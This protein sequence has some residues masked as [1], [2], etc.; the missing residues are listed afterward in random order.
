MTVLIVE[1][2]DI[3]ARVV[4]MLLKKNGF[5]AVISR[6][7]KEALEYFENA[8]QLTAAIV[9]IMMPEM[10]GFELVQRMREME[11]YTDLP[12]VMC[13]ALSTQEA[14]QQCSEQD[15]KYYVLKP[16]NEEELIRKLR[17][18]IEDSVPIREV[19]PETMRKLGVDG[20]TYDGTA[21]TFAKALYDTASE[22]ELQLDEK[23]SAEINILNLDE[24]VAFFGATRLAN[25]INEIR[26][27]GSPVMAMNPDEA[28]SFVEELRILQRAIVPVQR[29]AT[30]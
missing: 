27:P 7:A 9:D 16:V 28:S 6:N 17:M 11:A 1:D 26:E 15:L 20:R 18:A 29:A 24:G 19:K 12:I 13:S 25:A 10:D 4:E 5:E 14:I 30:I 8:P 2:Y 23:G 21:R 3:T 22:V